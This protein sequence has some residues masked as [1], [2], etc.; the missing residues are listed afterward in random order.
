MRYNG[1]PLNHLRE[2]GSASIHRTAPS[3]EQSGIDAVQKHGA[4]LNRRNARTHRSSRQY[5]VTENDSQNLPDSSIK[6]QRTTPPFS[7]RPP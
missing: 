7:D 6:H 2:Y 1:M 3:A 5:W 4:I